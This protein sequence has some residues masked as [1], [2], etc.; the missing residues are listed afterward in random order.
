MEK[1][2]ELTSVSE[3]VKDL[4]ESVNHVSL[5]Y[6]EI[7]S[8][9]EKFKREIK[10]LKKENEKQKNEL[11]SVRKTVNILDGVQVK[12]QCFLKANKNLIKEN[13]KSSVTD[14]INAAGCNL[15]EDDIEFAAIQN[16]LSHHNSQVVKIGFQTFNTKLIVMK[17]KKNLK[18][19]EN[20]KEVAIYDVLNKDVLSLF[21]YAK[22]L[23]K[24]GFHSVYTVGTRIYAKKAAD[25]NSQWIKTKNEVDKLLGTTLRGNGTGEQ[26]G[27]P[28]GR[29]NRRSNGTGRNSIQHEV[30]R[31]SL[32]Q[33]VEDDGEDEEDDEQY[34]T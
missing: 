2:N 21:N 34:H 9:M 10:E 30:R 23:T 28:R 16:K 8:Q 13:V 3:T 25:G 31:R 12:K 11:A 33:Q 14:I 5:Q 20:C 15:K 29:G 4:A 26:A 6:D 22:E 1:L 27:T 32:M 7:H 17:N 19:N 18:D 24:V